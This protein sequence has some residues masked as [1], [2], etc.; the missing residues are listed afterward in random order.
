MESWLTQH[1]H[2]LLGTS[3]THVVFPPSC[4]CVHIWPC[5]LFVQVQYAI[6][7]TVDVRVHV[8]VCRHCCGVLLLLRD[9]LVCL[10]SCGEELNTMSVHFVASI[11]GMLC[12]RRQAEFNQ[13]ACTLL[14]ISPGAWLD[15]HTGG[16]DRGHTMRRG[17]ASLLACHG[18]YQ[19]TATLSGVCAGCKPVVD[20]SP[21]SVCWS[22]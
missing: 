2:A 14:D 15:M 3:S 1:E 13:T 5:Q 22:R 19:K 16:R 8:A 6:R 20:C 21:L 18:C 11:C 10:C 4:C 12:T 7:E 9:L 17:H